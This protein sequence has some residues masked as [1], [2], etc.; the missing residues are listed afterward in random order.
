MY[1]RLMFVLSK[2]NTEG[3]KRSNIFALQWDI[4][5]DR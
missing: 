2:V 3:N 5:N 1:S 4:N